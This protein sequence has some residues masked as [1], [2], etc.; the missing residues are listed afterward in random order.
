MMSS[1]HAR[2]C[3]SSSSWCEGRRWSHSQNAPAMGPKKTPKKAKA[4]P[5]CAPI[6]LFVT[7]VQQAVRRAPQPPSGFTRSAARGPCAPP[8]P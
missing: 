6:P 3:V 1:A 7:N 5:V 2:L 4:P 8:P